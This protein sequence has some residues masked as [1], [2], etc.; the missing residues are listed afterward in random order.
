MSP[1]EPQILILLKAEA[2]LRQDSEVD[3]D[4]KEL[5]SKWASGDSCRKLWKSIMVFK[6]RDEFGPSSN[7]SWLVNADRYL[8]LS[9]WASGNS[10]MKLRR[11]TMDFKIERPIW[12]SRFS[13]VV[14]DKLI[15]SSFP[16]SH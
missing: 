8:L 11:S 9:R 2:R 14:A 5:L 13:V 15:F 4:P 12:P 1:K 10:G 16:N 6:G 3:V 7:A